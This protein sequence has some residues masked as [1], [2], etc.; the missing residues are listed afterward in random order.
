MAELAESTISKS[1]EHMQ[2]QEGRGSSEHNLLL[3][4]FFSDPLHTLRH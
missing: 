1:F 2:L 3:T 4:H